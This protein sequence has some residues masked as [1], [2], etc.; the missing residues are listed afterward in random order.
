MKKTLK[1]IQEKVLERRDNSTEMRLAALIKTVKE[2][3]D[4]IEYLE[5]SLAD[6]IS[7]I[8]NEQ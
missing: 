2:Q 5:K 3:A 8:D 4:R 6:I 7:I 1:E